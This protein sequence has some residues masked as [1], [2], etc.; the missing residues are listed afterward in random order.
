M[1]QTTHGGISMQNNVSTDNS[2]LSCSGG[3]YL[4]TICFDPEIITKACNNLKKNK[5]IHDI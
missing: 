5:T 2:D 1:Q 4:L 3:E